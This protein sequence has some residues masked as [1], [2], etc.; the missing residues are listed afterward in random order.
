KSKRPSKKEPRAEEF[1]DTAEFQVAWHRWR[2]E[3]DLNNL[4]VRR[5]RQR[6][7]HGVDAA[8][9]VEGIAEGPVPGAAMS[10]RARALEHQVAQLRDSMMLL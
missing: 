3:R 1:A 5:S 4:S 9:G 8:D 10:S 2:Q 7:R 6:T